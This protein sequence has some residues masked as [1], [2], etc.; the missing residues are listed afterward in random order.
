MIAIL[1]FFFLLALV[2]AMEERSLAKR[3]KQLVMVWLMVTE[4]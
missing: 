1:S 3:I 4:K 2:E